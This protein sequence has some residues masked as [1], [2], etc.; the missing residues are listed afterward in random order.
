MTQNRTRK[1]INFDEITGAQKVP[2]G[3]HWPYVPDHPHRILIV[4]GSGSGKTNA[5]MNLLDHQLDIDKIYLYVKDPFED[6]YQYLIRKREDVGQKYLSDPEAF[7]EWSKDIED[8]YPNIDDYNPGKQ[9]KITVVFD[10]MITD[11]LPPRVTELFI[12][13]RKLGISVIFITQSYFRVPKDIRLNC[14]HYFLMGIPNKKELQ[15]ISYNHAVELDFR[16]FK[17]LYSRC[18]QNVHDFMVID[19]TLPGNDARKF[20]RN[21]FPENLFPENLSETYKENGSER[22]SQGS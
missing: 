5:L 15:Q 2:H 3:V 22:E 11:K 6:K 17:K 12:R 19:T 18:V 10:D 14:T 13:G 20:R 16:D 8:V 7:V 21:L 4:G 1:M 9:R